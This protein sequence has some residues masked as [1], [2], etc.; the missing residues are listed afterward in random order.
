MSI[1]YSGDKI[2]FADSSV[3]SSAGNGFKN[4]IINGDMR[5]DQRNAGASTTITATAYTLDRWQA[6]CG[7]VS[8]K[9]SVQQNA[10]SVTP[11][12]GFV[13]YLGTTSASAYSISSSDRF[14]INQSIEGLNASDLGWGTANAKTVTLSFWVRSSLTGTFGGSIQNYAA[15]RSYPFSYTITSANT[16]EL[17]TITIPGDTSGTWLTT[18]SGF[19]TINFGLGT[20]STYS[21]TAGAWAT[22]DYRSSTSA[23]SV[24]GTN[25]ATFYITGVQLEVGS[26]ASSFESRDYGRELQLCQR[27]FEMSYPI[28]TAIASSTAAMCSTSMTG[29]LTT[30]YILSYVSYK[31][32][33]RAASTITIYDIAGNLNKCTRGNVAVGSADNSAVA[34]QNITANGFQLFSTGTYNATGIDFHY[35]ASAEL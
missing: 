23:T 21:G 4:R 24:V 10:G 9:F 11:P 6:Y 20:G 18:N 19:A 25:G 17:E 1:V 35:T 31:V 28:G 33:K 2:T 3:Q 16:W 13:N 32:P 26:S 34:T 12:T 30:S 7:G 15:T 22:A 29:I 14:G 5:I 8:S 27:Y